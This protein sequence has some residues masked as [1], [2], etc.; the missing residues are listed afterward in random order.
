MARRIETVREH[1]A[2]AYANLARAHAALDQ[3]VLKYGRIHHMIRAKMYNGLV[4]GKM[5]MR[6]IYDDERVKMR[7]GQTCCYCGSS[8]KMSID[9]L[10]PRI[11]GGPDSADN[12]VWSCQPCN[13]SKQGRDALKWLLTSER[14][15]SILLLRRYIKLAAA[16][17]DRNELMDIPLAAAL[18]RD[19]PIELGLLP[20]D[21][22][23]LSGLRLWVGVAGAAERM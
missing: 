21:Y 3:G 4:S 9:H 10:I 19:L 13:S 11:K 23:P 8:H 14:F 6:T 7:F 20:Y 17:C 2:W 5:S 15:P 22:P 16:H 1:I 12:L 18:E